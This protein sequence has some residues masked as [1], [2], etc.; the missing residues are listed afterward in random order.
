MSTAPSFTTIWA[1]T[2]AADPRLGLRARLVALAVFARFAKA[3]GSV[4][5]VSQRKAAELTGAETRYATN[6][7]IAE[8]V[9]AGYLVMT[10]DARHHDARRWR[11]LLPRSG[12]VDNPARG[13]V[14]TPL[15]GWR[16]DTSRGAVAARKGCRGDTQVL[17]SSE[18]S[19]DATPPGAGPEP[20][21]G[22]PQQPEPLTLGAAFD[23]RPGETAAAAAIRFVARAREQSKAEPPPE[24][25]HSPPEDQDQE[26]TEESPLIGNR[27][28]AV[29]YRP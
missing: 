29:G 28:L 9:K 22:A 18:I 21:R 10:A 14:V 11:L 27:V 6:R 7:A 17:S 19:T 20:P 3:D 13:G 16:G 25:R 8:L 2:V 4:P 23:Q 5:F 24:R 26:R 1:R 15:E 12:A